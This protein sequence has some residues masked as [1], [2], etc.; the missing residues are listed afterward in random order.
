M[1]DERNNTGQNWSAPRGSERR[2]PIVEGREL[3][4]GL[5]DPAPIEHDRE[6]DIRGEHEYP[7]TDDEDAT[8]P[9]QKE[10]DRLKARLTDPR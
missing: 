1:P 4:R 9:S 10:R 7:Q 8:R 2:D 6:D 3:G 5:P